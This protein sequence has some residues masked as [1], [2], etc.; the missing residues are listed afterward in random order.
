MVA[1]IKMVIPL[2]AEHPAHSI[3]QPVGSK[4]SL[5]GFSA[6]SKLVKHQNRYDLAHNNYPFA[7]ASTAAVIS[8]T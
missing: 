5:K 8:W 2:R 7:I 3:A 6:S 4:M 1:D